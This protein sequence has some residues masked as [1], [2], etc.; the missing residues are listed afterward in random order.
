MVIRKISRMTETTEQE[1]RSSMVAAND[2]LERSVELNTPAPTAT[3]ARAIAEMSIF[4]RNSL[5]P[6]SDSRGAV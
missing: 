5:T 4:L 2:A 1:K 3:R 6:L